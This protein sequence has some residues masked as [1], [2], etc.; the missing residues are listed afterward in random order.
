MIVLTP[1]LSFA[2]PLEPGTEHYI[3]EGLKN[4]MLASH[5]PKVEGW[6]GKNL[7]PSTV[8]QLD[9]RMIHSHDSRMREH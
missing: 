8:G 4:V 5:Y 2:F 7:Q 1:F 9:S 6:N 3:C